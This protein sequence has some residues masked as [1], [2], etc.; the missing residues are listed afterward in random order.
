MTHDELHG[1]L[2]ADDFITQQE[3]DEQLELRKAGFDR[4]WAQ[5]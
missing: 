4:R 5:T 2:S 1:L 3:R